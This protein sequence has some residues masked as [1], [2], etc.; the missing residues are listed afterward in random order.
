[1]LCQTDRD[2]CVEISSFIE[3]LLGDEKETLF[4][5]FMWHWTSIPTAWTCNTFM[6][7]CGL[8]LLRVNKF[9]CLPTIWTELRVIIA[10]K[11]STSSSWVGIKMWHANIGFSSHDRKASSCCKTQILL[12]RF[13]WLT[14]N[15]PINM[16]EQQMNANECKSRHFK[17]QAR[18]CQYKCITLHEASES[19]D[20]AKELQ[21]LMLG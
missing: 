8:L 15:V 10:R 6:E 14:A 13:W 1:L 19:T 16:Y 12:A 11:S 3:S 5:C 9:N 17:L 4:V 2:L 18:R 7:L 20:Y 21:L